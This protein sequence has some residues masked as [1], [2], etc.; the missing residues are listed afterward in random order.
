MVEKAMK[1]YTIFPREVMAIHKYLMEVV[2]SHDCLH[3]SLTIQ[4]M[5]KGWWK[6]GAV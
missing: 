1:T 5:K 4:Q 6:T 2:E 3:A